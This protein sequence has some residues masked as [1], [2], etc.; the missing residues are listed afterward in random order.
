MLSNCVF[1]GYGLVIIPTTI[2]YINV[3]FDIFVV[4]LLK[5]KET[6]F[7]YLAF[8]DV[9]FGITPNF[10]RKQSSGRKIRP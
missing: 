4:I 9:S 8:I 6:R 5:Q 3:L 7:Y 2:Y 1:P 10:F